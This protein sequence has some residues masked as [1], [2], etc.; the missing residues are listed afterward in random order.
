MNQQRI[1]SSRY[2]SVDTRVRGGKQQF[3]FDRQNE[4]RK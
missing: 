2:H 3:L 4:D 1:F